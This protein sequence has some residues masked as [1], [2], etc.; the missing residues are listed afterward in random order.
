MNEEPRTL[1]DSH[2]QEVTTLESDVQNENL[3]G[4]SPGELDSNMAW[5]QRHYVWMKTFLLYWNSIVTPLGIVGNVICIMVVSQKHNRRVSCN[6]YKGA[7]AV[8]DTFMLIASTGP[9][10]MSYPQKYLSYPIVKIICKVIAYGIFT[11]AST[12]VMIILA[13][14]AERLIAVTK[15][16]QAASLLSPR[17]AVYTISGICIFS[18]SYNIPVLFVISSTTQNPQC[19][20]SNSNLAVAY[21]MTSVC[22]T[23]VIPLFAISIMNAVILWGVKAAKKQISRHTA[24]EDSLQFVVRHLQKSI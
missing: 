6:I 22:V 10:L 12:G 14:L 24:Y 9:L 13:M 8:A 19:S 3:T 23:G 17:R 4:N 21:N 20:I 1:E 16:L 2:K 7:L 15:P 11:A 5:L 18:V